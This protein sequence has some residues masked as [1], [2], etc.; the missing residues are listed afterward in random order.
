MET[1]SLVDH[2][3][4]L[5][6]F[7]HWDPVVPG[8]ARGLAEFLAPLARVLR[9]DVESELA[10]AD[11]P[12]RNLANEWSGLLFPEGDEAQFADAY[13]QTLTYAL[14]L[15]RFEGAESL[16]PALAV[17]T[18]Q[19]EHG[20]LAEA[21][22]LL[23]VDSVRDALKMPIELLERA[24]G[25]VDA[26]RIIGDGDPWLYF[27][28]QF[29]GAYD[30][31]LRNDRGVYYTPVEV[32]RAQVRLAGDLL[33]NRFEK[34]LGYAA[35]EV[36]VLDP[37]VGT[38][39]YPLGVLDHATEV[40]VD[41]LGPGAV[42]EKLSDLA[43][44]LYA[45]EILV[46]PYSVAHLRLSQRLKDA[47]IDDATPKVYLTDTL[48][49]PYQ[50]S[51]FT[52]SVLQKRMTEERSRAQQVKKDTRVFVCLGNPPYDREERD[53]SDDAGQRKGGWVRHGDGGEGAPQPI[54][55][56]FLAPAREAGLGVHLKN[57]YNDYVYFWRWALWKVFDSTD[58]AGIVSFITASSYLRGPGF[59][60]MRRK[61]REVFDELWII[62]LEGDSLGAPEDRK[63]LRDPDSGRDCDRGPQ[64]SAATM[65]ACQGVEN[66]V[67]RLG[68]GEIVSLGRRASLGRYSVDRMLVGM[69][70]A[71]LSVG[72][73][74][75]FH[76]ACCHRCVPLATLRLPAEK[77]L[78][79]WGKHRTSSKS[80]GSD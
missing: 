52:A 5:R 47:G 35:D 4:L 36:V 28:E 76:L 58:D 45:F 64:C 34:T 6:D 15:A 21:L 31:K 12:L 77:D 1:S 42:P 10:K 72:R 48:E 79:C 40:V 39:T 20:L 44:R 67:Q 80:D 75:I 2:L 55:E 65:C 30:P 38:G 23:E 66:E 17:E 49:S 50:M 43:D 60:G 71:V 59:A 25:A 18:L 26:A 51:E 46:G 63:R 73:R 74:G 62:D 57:L 32:V 24:I 69:G 61:M 70:C 7:L 78:A 11:S 3:H 33:R 9:D 29:L 13:A 37:A 8:T 19:R 14:L 54:L 16:R 53:P 41:R 56:D 27:Y 68:R 22:R